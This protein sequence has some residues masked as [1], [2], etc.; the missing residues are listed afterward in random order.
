MNTVLNFLNMGNT[1]QSANTDSGTED[2]TITTSVRHKKD[3]N[4][5][6]VN[7][8]INPLLKDTFPIELMLVLDTS[9]SMGGVSMKNTD[10][11]GNETGYSFSRLDLLCHAA[12]AVCEML[13]ETH[14]LC[15]IKYNSDTNTL[16]PLTIMDINGK[17]KAIEKID[18]LT[19][20]G[21]TEIGRAIQHSFNE[22]KNGSENASKHIILLSDGEPNDDKLKLIN[23]LTDNMRNSDITFSTFIFGY[24]ADSTLFNNMANIGHG[25]YSFI[26]DCS[27]IGTVFS[28]YIANITNIQ[29]KKVS[30][31]LTSCNGCNLVSYEQKNVV[32]Y[33]LHKDQTKNILYTFKLHNTDQV[34]MTFKIISNFSKNVN[35]EIVPNTDINLETIIV[36]ECRTSFIK[37]VK[38]LVQQNNLYN[39]QRGLSELLTIL[40]NYKSMY[41]ENDKINCMIR[42]FESTNS[43]EGQLTKSFSRQDWYN[44]WGKHYALSVLRAHELEETNNYKTPS[45]SY[46]GGETFIK[47]RDNADTIFTMLPAPKPSLKPMGYYNSSYSHTSST[48]NMNV[49][50]PVS[51][52][53]FVRNFYGGCLDGECPVDVLDGKKYMSDIKK[54][55]IVRHSM[56]TSR[57][58]CLVRHDTLD[59]F[60]EYAVLC[61]KDKQNILPLKITKWHPVKTSEIFD[62]NPT[63]PNDLVNFTKL[64]NTN[65]FVVEKPK[66]V[67]NI[68]ME[69]GDYPWFTV[70]GFECVALGHKEKVNTVLAHDYYSERVVDDLKRMP[71]WDN[72]SVTISQKKVRDPITKNVIGLEELIY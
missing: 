60:T 48:S 29:I 3:N 1:T 33:N 21:G 10:D 13:N 50:V 11:N 52:D 34:S 57:V 32:V 4:V 67:Y 55:D 45:V 36:E 2:L 51:Q 44:K 25:M 66:Y 16:F 70:G 6:L 27:M 14:K 42:D 20:G 71:G 9:G 63:F 58:R 8:S 24:D 59:E 17:K 62:G 40:K 46:Y 15:I 41:S 69:E 5:C 35:I 19:P 49:P 43:D 39:Q 18:S 30:I 68:V 64:P 65:Y 28:N 22:F 54:G 12:R 37:Y 53:A 23:T 31:E 61:C 72:G 47:I 56:G 38:E 26:P 7:L